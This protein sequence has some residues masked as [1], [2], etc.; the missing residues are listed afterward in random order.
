MDREQI[1]RT[2]RA[3]AKVN[4]HIIGAAVGS[5]MT[6]KFASMGGADFLLALSAGK[7]RIMGRS[8]HAAYLCYGN[9]NRMVM[10]M[11]STELLPII[12]NTPVLFGLMATDPGIH[13]YDYLKEIRDRGFS[14]ISNYPT[15]SLID[16]RFREALEEEGNSFRTE[17][18]AVRLARYLDLFTVAFVTCRQEAEQML[19]AGADVLCVHLG[20]TTGGFLGAKRAHSLY[21]AKKIS[22]EIFDL[23]REKRPEV[24][25]MIYSGPAS[26]PIDMQYIYRTT[27]C[28]GYIGGS[29]FERIP[30]ERAILNTT[31][32]FKSY[33]GFAE[34]DPM[35]SIG[36][37]KLGRENYTAFVKKYIEEN[38]MKEIRMGD[39]AL[40]AHVTPSYLSTRFKADTGI[41]FTDYLLGYRME[42]AKELLRKTG[43]SCREAAEGAG[44]RDYTQFSKM[45]KKHTG[46]SPAA[47][48]KSGTLSSL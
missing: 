31:R 29:T 10:E 40:V 34:D 11:G 30:A 38:Y 24:L 19:D 2:L 48:R 3:Q 42:K 43:L 9:S 12:K 47:Y 26:T 32:S 14:G 35:A 25:R 1:L 20:L 8:S 7:Y 6:A 4:G 33:G 22:Q 45:F 46:I 15:M 28:Q 27:D 36:S 39:L 13:L 37:G 16:G 18:E 41:S 21:E 5:G 23:S 44:Y 17:T